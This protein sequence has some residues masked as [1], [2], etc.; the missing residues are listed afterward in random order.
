MVDG[1]R[2]WSFIITSEDT[3]TQTALLQIFDA[4]ITFD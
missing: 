2:L 1:D 4:S 3:D